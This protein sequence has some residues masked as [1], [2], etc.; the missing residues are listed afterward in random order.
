MK[1]G[2]PV[3]RRPAPAATGTPFQPSSVVGPTKLIDS[4]PNGPGIAMPTPSIR[5]AG[6]S[7]ASS[8]TIASISRNAVSGST[9]GSSR[10]AP[11]DDVAGEVDQ[12]RFEAE[13]GDMDADGEAALGIDRSV[14]AG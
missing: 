7:A 3:A 8:P 4:T 9:R 6:R 10:R 11:A 5:P 2:S 12:G 14:A 1:A 13:R